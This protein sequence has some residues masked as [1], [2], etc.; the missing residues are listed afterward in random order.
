MNRH[1]EI[2]FVQLEFEFIFIRKDDVLINSK[3]EIQMRK[4]KKSR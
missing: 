2:I 1:D 3:N 4:S